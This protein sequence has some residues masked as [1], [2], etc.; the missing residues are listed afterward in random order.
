MQRHVRK[1]TGVIFATVLAIFGSSASV[2]AD[3]RM[4][5][6][7][8]YGVHYLADSEE[9]P[10]ATCRY[11]GDTVLKAVRVRFPFVFASD[12]PD[13]QLVGWRAIAQRQAAGGK[14]WTS[15]ARSPIQFGSAR[16]HRP[17]NF[18][19]V[20]VDVA[21][22]PGSIYRVRVRMNWYVTPVG[23]FEQIEG[24]ATHRVDWYRYVLADANPGFCP[25][26][27]L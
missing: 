9:Y 12:H 22:V 10:G 20:K 25:G 17:A 8:T 19:D 11:D 18:A 5:H 1:G 27:I 23:E 3:T 7:G 24:K 13:G 26:A 15:V 16:D 14:G 4:G 21:G 2:A 6:Q